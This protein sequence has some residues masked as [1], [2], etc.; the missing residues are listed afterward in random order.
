MDV[1][2]DVEDEFGVRGVAHPD[3]GRSQQACGRSGDLD[4]E[5]MRPFDRLRE[6][7]RRRRR[8]RRQDDGG[9]ENAAEGQ[10]HS[11]SP[12]PGAASNTR[13]LLL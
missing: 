12:I 5:E 13:V 4:G 11:N 6:S 10:G 1:L 3:P 7:G 2:D 8:E 9:R